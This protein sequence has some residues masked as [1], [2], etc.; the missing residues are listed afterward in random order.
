MVDKPKSG[1]EIL[2]SL[3][4]RERRRFELFGYRLCWVNASVFLSLQTKSC[5]KSC[6]VYNLI[7]RHNNNVKQG[8]DS[9]NTPFR[10]WPSKNMPTKLQVGGIPAQ[11]TSSSHI[12]HNQLSIHTTPFL[13]KFTF[14]LTTIPSRDESDWHH[15]GFWLLF[16]RK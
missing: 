4:P 8:N 7:F 2:D 16:C 11:Q 1:I 5:Y 15:I 3:K 14:T 13:S 6:C 12:I 9:P 10:L